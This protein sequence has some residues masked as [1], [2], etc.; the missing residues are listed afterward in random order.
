MLRG[1]QSNR[2]GDADLAAAIADVRRIADRIADA[3]NTETLLGLEGS[4]SRKY[5]A[6]LGRGFAA[7]IMFSGRVKRPPTDPANALLSLAYVMLGN[8]IT[9]LLEA[10]GLDPS[11]GFYHKLRPARPS[12]ALDLVEELR[13]PVVDRFV[14]RLCNLRIVR[15]E[16]FTDGDEDKGVR[17]TQDGLR[18][19]VA[20]WEKHLDR[21]VRERGTAAALSV[22]QVMRRQAERLASDLRGGEAY[23]PLSITR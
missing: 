1:L 19:F 10:R 7:D 21:P 9:A 23:Q 16:M 5:F 15:L 11:I 17:L 2:P 22:H 3:D 12:L 20:E 14:L 8:L 13:A 6:G 4:A 18:V